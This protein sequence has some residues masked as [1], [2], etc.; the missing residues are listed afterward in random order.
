MSQLSIPRIIHQTWKHDKDL[1]KIESFENMPDDFKESYISWKANH[2]TWQYIFWTDEMN[3]KLIEEDFP[4]FLSYYDNFEYNIQRADA[5]RYF[6]LYKYG[7]LYVDLDEKSTKPI[8]PILEEMNRDGYQLGFVKS[9]TGNFTFS[10]WLMISSKENPFWKSVWIELMKPYRHVTKHFTV[11]NSTGPGMLDRTIKKENVK[12]KLLDKGFH[13]CGLCDTK[14]CEK[15]GYYIAHL[16]GQSWN[17]SVSFLMIKLWCNK[18]KIMLFVIFV[19]LIA[20]TL[21][22][23]CKFKNNFDREQYKYLI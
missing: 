13:P 16:S 9:A 5:I 4:W 15:E 19:V 21:A 10:N 17:N 18:I 22:C 6:I 11:I 14:P 8:D 2:P 20:I 12:Y 1:P 3:R 7:G 23:F